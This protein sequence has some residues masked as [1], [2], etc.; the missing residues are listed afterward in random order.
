MKII[1]NFSVKPPKKGTSVIDNYCQ[2]WDANRQVLE[3]QD[4]KAKEQGTLV[5]RL[6]REAYADSYACYVVIKENK[7][8]VRIKVTKGVGDDWIIPYWGE[9]T[10]IDKDYAIKHLRWAEIF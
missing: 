3:E 2:Q 8:T 6:I 5:G 10:T 7:K 1:T 9:E 4:R